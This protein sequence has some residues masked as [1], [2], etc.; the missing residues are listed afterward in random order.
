MA[1]QNNSVSYG[2][3]GMNSRKA[4]QLI[5]AGFVASVVMTGLAYLLR[6]VGIPAPDFGAEYGAILNGQEYPVPMSGLWTAGLAWHLV[7]GTLI[8]SFLFDYLAHRTVLPN[9]RRSKGVLYGLGIWIFA[10]LIVAPIAGEGLFFRLLAAPLT[11]AVTALVCWLVYGLVLDEMT[12]VRAV[13][14]LDVSDR[15]AA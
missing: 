3:Y 6:T 8:F 2:S 12:R 9:A 15:S 13:H 11:V 1:Y 5:L 14:Y 4:T 10:G 7:N